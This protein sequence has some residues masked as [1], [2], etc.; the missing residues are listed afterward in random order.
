MNSNSH[1]K[2]RGGFTLTE[3]LVVMG[4]IAILVAISFPIY[5]SAIA[6]ANIAKCSFNLR[7][8]GAGM[9]SFAA[10]NNNNLP[11]SGAVIPY[12]A[13]DATTQQHGWTQQLEPYLGTGK[14]VYQCP[15]S[16]IA[17]P[18]NATYSYFNGSHAALYQSQGFSAVNLTRMHNL[19]QHIIGGD[20]AFNGGFTADDADKDDYTQDP[21]F[22]GNSGTIPIHMGS[23]NVVFADGH[24]ENAKKFDKDGMTTVYDGLGHDYLP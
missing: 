13:I 7:R 11:I 19:S 14:A 16:S 24:V 10:D 2:V 6:H 20:I 5:R 1:R 3:L 21:A 18:Q 9:L 17:I 8:I 15:D 22:N 4:I 12:D 23:S